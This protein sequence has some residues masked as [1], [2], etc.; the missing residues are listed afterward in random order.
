MNLN[1]GSL[2]LNACLPASIE[3]GFVYLV[4]VQLFA[5]T[6]NKVVVFTGLQSTGQHIVN[7]LRLNKGYHKTN[8]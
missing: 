4:G 2:K 3:L 6:E 8:K 5:D 7:T 1:N